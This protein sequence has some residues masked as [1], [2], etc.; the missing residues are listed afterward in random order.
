MYPVQKEIKKKSLHQKHHRHRDIAERKMEEEVHGFAAD[1]VPGTAYD[2]NQVNPGIN[3]NM[4]VYPVIKP[5]KK[6]LHQK[7]EKWV[8]EREMDPY[9]YDFVSPHIDA[10][11]H[12]EN[13]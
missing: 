8:A 11:N 10:L 12:R 7:N 6:S 5:T 4:N 2:R 9:V 1:N 13:N 3:G